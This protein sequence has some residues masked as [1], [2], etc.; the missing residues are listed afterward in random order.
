MADAVKARVFY[1]WQSDTPNATNRSFILKALEDAA[2][3]IA[4]DDSIKV[5]PVVDRD[6]WG[7]AGSPDI[8]A[9]ILDKIKTADVVVADVTIINSGSA[10]R[11]MPNPNVAVGCS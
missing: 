3:E 7:V 10:A 5:E 4:R 11:L 9:T 8:G 6:T 1:S 2:K